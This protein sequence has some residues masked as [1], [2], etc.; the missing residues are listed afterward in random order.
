SYLC[1]SVF[2][3]GF[4]SFNPRSCVHPCSPVVFFLSTPE[5]AQA[6]VVGDAERESSAEGVVGDAGEFAQGGVN[7][8]GP[9]ANAALA[10]QGKAARVD[11]HMKLAFVGGADDAV[12]ADAPAEE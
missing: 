6:L 11:R 8:L 7:M 5:A 12:A 3:C 10:I 2:T 1:S 4:F 9:D